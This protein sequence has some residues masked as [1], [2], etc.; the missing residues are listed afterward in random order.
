MIKFPLLSSFYEHKPT[1]FTYIQ[2]FFLFYF[3][4]L[5]TIRLFVR[6]HNQ[7]MYENKNP[8]L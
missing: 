6:E 5:I 4:R 1:K 7:I 2:L 3:V 8:A